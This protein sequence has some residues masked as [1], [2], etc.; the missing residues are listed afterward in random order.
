MILREC[1]QLLE[2]SIMSKRKLPKWY[3][4]LDFVISST[5]K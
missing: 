2:L 4:N 3:K 1:E 5:I